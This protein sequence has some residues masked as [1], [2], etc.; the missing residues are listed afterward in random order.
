M[1]P[2]LREADPEER[3]ATSFKHKDG[4]VVE[5]YSAYKEKTVLRHFKWRHDYG[6]DGVFL[7]RF[8][9]EVINDSGRNHFNTVLN[10]ARKG[11]Q[12][13]GRVY[14]MMYDLAGHLGCRYRQAVGHRTAQR[15]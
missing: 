4:R 6:L 7:Q 1:W 14:R 13:Y 11:A 15:C 3:F 2:D 12:T 9:S 10:L 5:V 8:A